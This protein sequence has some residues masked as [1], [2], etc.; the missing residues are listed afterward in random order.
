[1]FLLVRYL[2]KSLATAKRRALE[3]LFSRV[4]SKVV[5]QI[6][7]FSEKFAAA[8]VVAR[9]NAGKPPCFGVCEFHLRELE[10]VGNVYLH[11]E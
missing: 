6:V 2:V 11:V 1:M 3:G 7:P 8:A 4:D 10:S 5:E 9:E